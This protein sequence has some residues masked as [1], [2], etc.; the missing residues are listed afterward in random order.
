M[1]RVAGD[2]A[3]PTIGVVGASESERRARVEAA[4]TDARASLVTGD[5]SHVVEPSPTFVVA[6]G[7]RA[8]CSL[9]NVGVDAP[10]LAVDAGSGVPSVPVETVPEAIR[11]VLTGETARDARRCFDVAIDGETHPALYDVTLVTTEPA[12]I[13]EYAVRSGGDLVSR[14][15]AD[16]V[17]VATPT[18]SHGYA[19]AAGSPLL[20]P[21]TGTATVVPIAPFSIQHDHWILSDRA[22]DL[23]VERDEG[24][25]SLF[26]DDRPV[27]EVGT[28][29][30][31]SLTPG[32]SLD[33]LSPPQASG[34][35]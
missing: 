10:V 4:V 22:V 18:G 23:S 6:V 19:G 27:H 24:P 35:W 11:S 34:H 15:R 25:V 20:E 8:L 16:G 12:R 13:S 7:E 17:V 30:T 9:V 28:D 1:E 29:V 21:G 14:F 5:A 2:E 3:E 26:V 33:L 31:V 32:A